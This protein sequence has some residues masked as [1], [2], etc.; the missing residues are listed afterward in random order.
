MLAGGLV[1]ALP[2]GLCTYLLV[3]RFFTRLRNSRRRAHLLN[4]RRP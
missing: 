2:A 3:H 4:D 1:L